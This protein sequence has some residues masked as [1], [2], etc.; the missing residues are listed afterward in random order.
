[1]DNGY[2]EDLGE[3]GQNEAG[4]TLCEEIMEEG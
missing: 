2:T 1:M 4:K 3:S